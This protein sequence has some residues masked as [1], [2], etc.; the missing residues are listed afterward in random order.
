[1][2][3]GVRE[4]VISYGAFC[5]AHRDLNTRRKVMCRKP[6]IKLVAKKIWHL[7]FGRVTYK[8]ANRLTVARNSLFYIETLRD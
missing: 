6:I 3:R 1:M 4:A 8:K 5:L 7:K 2:R